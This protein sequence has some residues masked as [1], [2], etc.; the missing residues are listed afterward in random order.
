MS[1]HFTNVLP[2]Q[3]L[4][5][6][7]VLT[8]IDVRAHKHTQAQRTAVHA[9][10][11]GR[12]NLK[13]ALWYISVCNLGQSDRGPWKQQRKKVESCNIYGSGVVRV[14]WV[15]EG[16]WRARW[17]SRMWS[18]ASVILAARCE[19]DRERGREGDRRGAMKADLLPE[20]S[21]ERNP[22]N[23]RCPGNMDKS[24]SACECGLFSVGFCIL[25][26]C[27]GPGCRVGDAATRD[28]LW[29]RRDVLATDA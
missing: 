18:P 16:D 14:P 23:H 25:L 12:N 4:K 24:G 19:R 26:Q 7:P 22:W 6:K 8:K 13:N 20:M 28:T 11:I 1:S 17:T 29:F 5:F 9:N 27:S 3:G 2:S 15:N 10:V 21:T